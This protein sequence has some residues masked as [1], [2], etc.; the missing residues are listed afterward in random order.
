MISDLGG[1]IRVRAHRRWAGRQEETM[2]IDPKEIATGKCFITAG[3]QVRRV[4]GTRGADVFYEVRSRAPGAVA[5]GPR[6][7]VSILNFAATV[8]REVPFD[9]ATTPP[10]E[11]ATPTAPPQAPPAEAGPL[12]RPEPDPLADVRD[13]I[14]RALAAGTPQEKLTHLY[15]AAE[16]LVQVIAALEQ[17]P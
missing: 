16:R 14:D 5:W 17:R 3:E 6:K 1:P 7:T 2:P 12:Q 4:L 8:E 15:G 10:D 9:V 13:F 11:A